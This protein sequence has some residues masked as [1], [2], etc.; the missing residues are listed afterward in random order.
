MKKLFKKQISFVLAMLMLVVTAI[1]ILVP[2][3]AF[4]AD[5]Y[6]LT[7]KNEGK[8]AHTFEIY[9][10]F[11]GDLSDSILTNIQW[12]SGIKVSS[13]AA[14]G[15]ANNKAKTL[16]NEQSAQ[17]FAED[18][19]EHLD[20]TNK[21]EK[22]VAANSTD[23]VTGLEPGYYLIKDKAST[24]GTATIENG[25]YTAYILKIV[26]NTEAKT[27]LDVP[28]VVK[29]VK[30]NSNQEWQ[31]AADYNIGD[32]I[33][34]KLTGTLPSNY[35][36]YEKYSYKFHDEMS[37]GLTFNKNSIRVTVGSVVIPA[38]KYTVTSTDH[39]FTLAFEDLKTITNPAMTKD[40]Q[41][42]VEYTCTLNDAAVIGSA[43]NP[44]TAYLEYSNNPNKGGEG[45]LGKTPKDKNIVFTYKVIVNKKND[46][47]EA[48]KGAEFK[49]YK[50][51]DS[52]ETE[53]TRFTIDSIKNALGTI[54]TF[55]GLDAGTYVL[56][57]TK[58]PAGYNK[59]APIE[60][61]IT[62]TYDKTSD[63]PKLTK[64]TGT[65]GITFTPV[66]SD[67]SLS[68]DVIN[69]K[70]FELPETGGMGR[71]L[72]YAVGGVFV[73]VSLGYIGI[74]RSRKHDMK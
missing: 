66:L 35:D 51:S 18:I 34:Y 24:Q 63:D 27:K 2:T 68:A 3:R 4:A 30:E 10:I 38:N 9:Q 1:S 48:L 41:I 21:K 74:K 8:T 43:G 57:E 16:T 40:S 49:L 11:K 54:F 36:K 31:D 58:V 28:T 29:K 61:T 20:T 47:N 52:G 72:I 14:L 15:D 56:K 62:A 60:F 45:D 39:S 71:H 42:V 37:S 5:T 69:N 44:N 73:V 32:T 26:K 19:Q 6:T 25:A 22:E 67:G 70:G 46:K 50:K 65:G 53:I 33:P 12:G 23:T 64:L 55:K 17:A 7:L 59:I 13:L